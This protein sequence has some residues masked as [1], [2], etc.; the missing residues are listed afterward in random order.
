MS[1]MEEELFEFLD[2][3]QEVLETKSA[4]NP[5]VCIDGENESYSDCER[6]VLETINEIISWAR[7]NSLSTVCLKTLTLLELW[8]V[9]PIVYL[10]VFFTYINNL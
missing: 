3:V 9:C 4:T 2:Q 7:Q 1:Y 6:I 10:Q 5:Q 8:P